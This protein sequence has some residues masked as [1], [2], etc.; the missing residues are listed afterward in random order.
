M[1]R[2]PRPM[3]M[4]RILTALLATSALLL[5]AQEPALTDIEY[6]SIGGKSLRLDLYLPAQHGTPLLVYVHGGAWRSGSKSS[7]PV[8][9]LLNRGFAIA[10]VDYRLSTEAV[11]P[12]EAH[13]IKA[14]IRF[15]RA[16]ATHYHYD[17]TRI[18]IIGTSA[19]GHLAA[20]VGLT[21]GNRELE[22]QVGEH[23]AQSSDVQCVV[24][25]FGASNL[26]TILAQSTEHGLKVRVPALQLLLGGQPDGKADLARLASPVAH[27][28]NSDPPLL[29]IHGDADPQM[30][31][32]Q[33]EEL[34]R[35]CR[36]MS[37]P[38]Q[39]L[40]IPGAAHGGP[41]FFDAERLELM[42]SFL[43][44]HLAAKS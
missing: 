12:A 3:R 19:G 16:Q 20:L 14:A 35:A 5:R 13:D 39:H 24:S 10:S 9:K 32:Q 36:A 31:P 6:A 42:A 26:Q 2:T 1:L 23:L 18:G 41:E 8:L 44:N 40:R 4:A 17:G 33:S 25:L 43:K 22:G 34:A 37:L 7:V 29:L 21:N 15:L 11:F 28:D 27:V 30:P 38:V